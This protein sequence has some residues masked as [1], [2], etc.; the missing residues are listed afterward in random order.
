M[1]Y[2]Y[3]QL[4]SNNKNWVAQKKQTDTTY[5]KRL[6]SG[7]KP[8]FLYIGCSDSRMPLDTFTQTE[9][10]ELFVHRNIANQV[11]ITDLNFLSVL[12]YAVNYLHVKH[13][14]VC[15]HYGCAGVS[16]AY[17]G[18]AT[19]L[20]GNW[21]SPISDIA[22][23]YKDELDQIDDMQERMNRLSELNVLEQVRKLFKIN[24]IQQVLA[25]N[26]TSIELHGWILDLSS[27]LIKELETDLKHEF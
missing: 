12:D 27:G 1:P 22:S 7:Q 18:Q 16:E 25:E 20:V 17:Q 11:S 24:I 4:I 23:A 15:G 3:H 21:I 19:G 10:G 13:I 8:L 2:L 26:Q 14:I 5:F 6:S 9:P